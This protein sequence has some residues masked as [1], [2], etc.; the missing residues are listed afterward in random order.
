MQSICVKQGESLDGKSLSEIEY[1]ELR[2]LQLCQI[3]DND[4]ES[5]ESFI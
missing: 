3:K 4:R 1:I 5:S 2:I